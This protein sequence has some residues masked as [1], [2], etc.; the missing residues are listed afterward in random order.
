MGSF[1]CPHFNF[2]RDQCMRLDEN[3]VPGRPGCVLENNS[4]FSVPVEERL[5]EEEN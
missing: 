5:K 3:C 2:N 4:N 1:S